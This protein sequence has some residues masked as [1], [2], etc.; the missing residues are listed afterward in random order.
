MGT[1]LAKKDE[2][3]FTLMLP[4]YLNTRVEELVKDPEYECAN[5]ARSSKTKRGVITD[6][7][8][9]WFMGFQPDWNDIGPVTPEVLDQYTTIM[10]SEF[11]HTWEILEPVDQQLATLVAFFNH[12]HDNSMATI[13]DVSPEYVRAFRMS[14][15]G[16]AAF[17]LFKRVYLPAQ[18]NKYLAEH[19]ERALSGDQASMKLVARMMVPGEKQR[20][21]ITDNRGQARSTP[22]PGPERDKEFV[23]AAVQIKMNP[24]RFIQLWSELTS[25]PVADIIADINEQL[26]AAA[27]T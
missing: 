8:E 7:L 6:I 21:E 15:D 12:L 24:I 10:V 23:E 27:A 5:K 2:I 26:A 4:V 1:E 19:I 17:D 16:Q 14:A 9:Q 3:E 13:V 25:E 20:V 11:G 22:K 18:Q